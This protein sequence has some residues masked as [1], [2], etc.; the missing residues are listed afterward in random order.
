MVVHE[1]MCIYIHY[2]YTSLVLYADRSRDASC[3]LRLGWSNLKH[4]HNANELLVRRL[5]VILYLIFKFHH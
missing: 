2:M 5:Q 3:A 4:V 1:A